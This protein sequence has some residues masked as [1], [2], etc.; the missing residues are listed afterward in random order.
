MRRHCASA[1]ATLAVLASF[2]IVSTVAAPR[3]GGQAPVITPAG[4]PSVA[5]DSIYRLA[6]DPATAG[7]DMVVYLFDD[8]VRRVELDGSGSRTYRQVIQVL[9]QPAVNGLAERSIGYQPDRQRFSLNWVRVLRP[10]GEVISD[11]PA[12]MQETDPPAA[13]SNPIYLTTKNVRISLS[14]VEVGAIVD[15]SYTIEDLT[16]Y[17][18]GDRFVEWNVNPPGA[19]VRRSRLLVDAPSGVRP[20]ITEQNLDFAAVR[21]VANGRATYAWLRADPPKVSREPFAPDTSVAQM[22]IAFS[23]PST[24]SDIAAWYG[25]LSRDRYALGPDA[26]GKVAK[27]VAAATTRQ[28]TIRAVHRWV[29][30]DVRYV[31]ILLG[32]GS[33]QPRF[34]DSVSSTGVGDCKDKTTLFVA[35]LRHLGIPAVPVLTRNQATGLRRAHASIQQF[36][37][38]IA[39]VVERNGYVFTDLT[40]SYTPY[41]E[42]PWPEQGGFALVVRTDGTGEALTLPRA[43]A[44]S[45]R[46]EVH[47]VATMSDSG[48]MT[49]HFDERNFGHGFEARRVAFSMPLDSARKATVMR[50]LLA[51]LPGAVGDSM[52]AFSGRDLTA[53][54]AYR[55]YFSRARGITNAGGLGLFNFPFGVYPGSQRAATLARLP[56]RKT[57]I[58]AE[59][60]LL[61]RPSGVREVTMQVTLPEGWRARVPNDVVVAGDFGRY[62]TVYRQEGR[63]LTIARREESGQGIFPPSRLADVISFYKAISA[64]EENRTLVIDRP[65]K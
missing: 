48:L 46:I 5:S 21:T 3:A 6:I 2:A 34:A 32:M 14:G 10:T 60:V 64:D 44:G 62:S 8:A 24:W 37:H 53:Q 22:R 55:M 20:I 28:D 41:G 35:A 38:V 9:K 7:E 59:E 42:I 15:V 63:V 43:A 54:P 45:R 29:A 12:H 33:Y 49:G 61:G 26:A 11:K 16:P 19:R 52:T 4:D 30:Q 39:A 17:R 1:F 18:T 36:N 40:S 27:L 50:G 51:I 23:L 56:A 58:D 47:V 25:T 31:A 13:M 65:A 57:L